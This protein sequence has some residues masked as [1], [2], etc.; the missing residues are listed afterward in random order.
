[1]N[2]KKT[3]ILISTHIF[4]LL[5]GASIVG[6]WFLYQGKEIFEQGNAMF[7]GSV[8]LGRYS[9]YLQIQRNEAEPEQYKIA[10]LG[11]IEELDK[12]DKLQSKFYDKKIIATDKALTYARLNR[13][14][15]N[16][17]KQNDYKALSIQHC[18]EAGLQDCTF[19]NIAK[20]TKTI[21]KTN[22][23]FKTKNEL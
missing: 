11:F 13:L 6:G 12:I 23:W 20:I 15:N 18:T 4:A 9:A 22:S 19:E 14:E 10:L 7:N 17:E 1:M 21:E 2:K 16:Q 3:I 5:I 8:L